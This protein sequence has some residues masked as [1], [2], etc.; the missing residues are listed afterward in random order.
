MSD[1]PNTS[2]SINEFN[3]EDLKDK[4]ISVK[5]EEIAALRKYIK[6]LERTKWYK[7]W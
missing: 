5:D 2:S 7:L 1:R 4:L 6:E 3:S